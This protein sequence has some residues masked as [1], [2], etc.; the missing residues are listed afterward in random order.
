MGGKKKSLSGPHWSTIAATSSIRAL[1][2]PALIIPF[3]HRLGRGKEK[4]RKRKK[5]KAA[6]HLGNLH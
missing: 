2:C 1:Y 3:L 4:K 5:E 6:D